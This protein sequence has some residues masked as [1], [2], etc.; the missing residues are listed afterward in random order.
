MIRPVVVFNNQFTRDV[1]TVTADEVYK[2]TG[3]VANDQAGDV[4][5][6]DC[7]VTL[8]T[9]VF[10]KMVSHTKIARRD[11]IVDDVKRQLL[12]NA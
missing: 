4:V 6:G 12:W 2:Q 8:V 7:S 9:L 11:K 10:G 3:M 5:K 1:F